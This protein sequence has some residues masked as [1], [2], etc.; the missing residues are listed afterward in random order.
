MKIL[1]QI[2]CLLYYFAPISV[3]AQSK[4][5]ADTIIYSPNY[6]ISKQLPQISKDSTQVEIIAHID[7]ALVWMKEEHY[8]FN[9]ASPLIYGEN[10][11]LLARKI[12]DK[13]YLHKT[14]SILG[15]IMLRIKDTAN[16]KA[17]FLKSLKDAEASNDS[18]II[19]ASKGNLANAY[20]YTGGFKH[21]AIATYIDGLEIAKRINDTVRIF[22]MHHNVS[23]I[24]IENEDIENSQYHVSKSARYLEYLDDP[25]YTS[26]QLRNEG[27]LYVLLNQPDKA[28]ERFKENIEIAESKKMMDGIIEGYQGYIKALELKE[29]YKALYEVSKKLKFYTD[30]KAKD[31][32][33]QTIEAVT[34]SISVARYKEQIKSKEL[35]KER[36][37]HQA[38]D[39]GFVLIVVLGVLLFISIIFV[40][41][42]K[43]NIKRKVLIKHLKDKN[44]QY[45]EAKMQSDELI[46]AKAKF[47]ATVSHELRTPLY[48]VIGLSSLLLEDKDLKKHENDLKSL[49]FSAN[50][51]L[52]LVNDLLHI[53]KIDNNS[54]TDEEVTFNIEDLSSTIISSFEY[55]RLQ[56]DNKIK[57][58]I[59]KDVPLLL[60]G[61]S[62]RL[63]QIFMN[64]IG[65]ACKFTEK[66]VISLDIKV[67]AHTGNTV[68]L[69]F[70]IRDTGPGIEQ[71]RL[72]EI[73][74]EFTQIKSELGSRMYQGTGLGLSIVKKLVEQGKGAIRVTSKIGKGTTFQFDLEIKVASESEKK[75][76]PILD[77]KQLISKRILI[78]EDNRINQTV[79]KRILEQ[80]GAI[81]EIAQNGEEAIA[82]AKQFSYDLILMDIN[83]PVKN[84]IEATKGIRTFDKFIPIIAL[85]AVEIEEQKFQ[86][87]ECGMNDIILKPYDIDLFKK[88]I[89]ANLSPQMKDELRELA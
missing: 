53:N 11:L 73:F 43:S 80:A 18:T 20:Y 23:R 19:L 41:T 67:I 46:K 66:G 81:C 69:Q 65:N 45:L 26:G 47:F 27:M 49:K 57:I 28:I 34:S 61:N 1:A 85:T 39:R 75:F 30:K 3:H 9:F 48:G 4:Y 8:K 6:G 59:S 76:V 29:D 78:V 72:K 50:Y 13:S 71:H 7:A 40:Q 68:R 15:N 58:N 55:V 33:N 38:E 42:Y 17:M 22:I 82:L 83:M 64:L 63:S 84:G 21:K 89:I 35:E 86:I 25:F 54:F 87:F 12:N 60:K 36:L 16:A 2:V 70:I 31:D 32:D 10:A 51:L 62:V 5:A 14:R 74:N 44:A 37:E 77:F 24:F 52:A 79:T 56:H 88:T